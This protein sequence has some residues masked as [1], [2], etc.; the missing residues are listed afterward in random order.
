M[1]SIHAYLDKR[2]S[3]RHAQRESQAV[4][5]GPA[6]PLHPQAAADRGRRL[7]GRDRGLRHHA[8]AIRRLV[9]HRRPARPRPAWRG[10][11]HRLRRGHPRGRGGPAPAARAGRGPDHRG[12]DRDDRTAVLDA[13]R[14]SD[15][16]RRVWHL[17]ATPDGRA[18]VQDMRPAVQAAQRRILAPLPAA[19]RPEFLRMLRQLVDVNN[20]L[21]R[22][23]RGE[24]RGAAEMARG[25][26]L[27]VVG[28]R[29]ARPAGGTTATTAAPPSASTRPPRPRKAP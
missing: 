20:G 27:A 7:P 28:S 3:A 25:A 2:I 29:A 11:C 17:H 12:A 18:L 16:D 13:L 26:T 24:G 5:G 6:G 22:A 21:S 4:L 9:G 8:R 1:I 14:A 23:P 10:A 19:E 15:A